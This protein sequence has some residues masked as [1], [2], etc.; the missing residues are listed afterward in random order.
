MHFIFQ[1]INSRGKKQTLKVIFLLS[2][3][4]FSYFCLENS[5]TGIVS[6]ALNCVV[7]SLLPDRLNEFLE[8]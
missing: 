2:V 6:L 8:L 7:V 1:V 4:F 3:F 5:F